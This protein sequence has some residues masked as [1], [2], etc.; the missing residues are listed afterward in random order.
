MAQVTSFR[1]DKNNGISTAMHHIQR[2]LSVVNGSAASGDNIEV[3]GQA[4]GRKGRI[5]K[6]IVRTSGSL[7][8]SCVVTPQINVSG[9]RTAVAG[10]TTAG[11]ASKVESDADSDVPFDL[12][13]G[14]V[15]EL[16]VSGA[17]IGATATITVDI[18]ESAR[19]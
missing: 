2:V 18:Y 1:S 8:A 7:G 9:T 16:A 13:G 5:H 6:V 12:S 14:E 19:P 4:P 10:G 15:L 11:S 3:W 17:G